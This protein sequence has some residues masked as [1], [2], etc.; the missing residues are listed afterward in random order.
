[1]FVRI[2]CR[3]YSGVTKGE[4]RGSG[5]IK[6]SDQAVSDAFHVWHRSSLSFMMWNL[7]SNPTTLLNDRLWYR[8]SPWSMNL[9]RSPWSSAVVVAGDVRCA[10]D[11]CQWVVYVCT[12]YWCH[13]VEQCRKSVVKEAGSGSI[14]LS[15]Q[16]IS[17]ASKIRFIFYVFT[18]VF[19]PSWCETCRVIQ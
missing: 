3:Q 15:H 14:R 19:H 18:Q 2:K 7:H 16:T 8:T 9:A 10:C 13:G 17:G 6:S 4:G 11:V 5:L 12:C 1:M